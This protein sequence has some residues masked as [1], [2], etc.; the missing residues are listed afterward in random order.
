[1]PK[2]YKKV[3]NDS[4]LYEEIFEQKEVER[5][6]QYAMKFFNK[7]IKT[8][9]IRI[10][11]HTWKQGDK[12]YK[13]AGQYYSNPRLWWVIAVVNKISSEADLSYGQVIKVP[14]E[15]SEIVGRI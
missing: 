3:I 7:S 13:L 15:A 11:R 12:L 5:I 2:Y 4:E 6:V 1:M 10:T 14:L 8:A 9:P